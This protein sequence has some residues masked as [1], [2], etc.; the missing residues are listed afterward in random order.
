MWTGMV[1]VDRG[2]ANFFTHLKIVESSKPILCAGNIFIE[3]HP[4]SKKGTHILWPEEFKESLNN[5]SEP[6]GPPDNKPWR[7][8]CSRDDFEF[9]N[10]VHDAAL[11]Q[12]QTERLIKFIR[13]CQ[14]TPGSFM[15]HNYSD[16]KTSLENT[17]KLLTPVIIFQSAS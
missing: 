8:F 11:N 4:Y 13:C 7:P 14:D 6:T 5:H 2:M 17:S 15:L 9:T 12:T 16:L 10:I 3:Y 1:S